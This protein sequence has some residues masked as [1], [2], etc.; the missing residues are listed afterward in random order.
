MKNNILILTILILGISCKNES[1]KI[2][3][4]QFNLTVKAENFPD[5]TKVYLYNRDIDKNIDSTYVINKT[6]EFSGKIDLPSLTYL[7]FFDKTGKSIEPYTYFYLENNLIE[8]EG[9]YDDFLN[10]K[11]TGSNQTD[12]QKKYDSIA[13]FIAKKA[14]QKI[15]EISDSIEIIKTKSRYNKMI[16]K[17]QNEF[18]FNHANNQMSIH[19]LLY[20]KKKITKDSLLVFYETLDSVNAHSV[21]GNELYQ[22]A[23]SRDIKVGDHYRD[24][25]GIDLDGKNHNLSDYAG[26]VILLDF[27]G[28]G[29]VPC[30]KQNKSEFQQLYNKYENDSFVLISYSLDTQKKFWKESSQQDDIRWVNISDLQGIMGENAKKYAVQAIPNSFLIDQNGI[31]VKSFIGF[32][33]GES[34]IED[35]IDKILK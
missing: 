20:R 19:T 3:S 16:W 7:N 22:Y 4:E 30:R 9:E 33:E 35:E 10:A 21:K 12:L 6:F 25:T 13:T 5:S 23:S 1:E 24:I 31:I 11:I 8:I 27:W 32:S 26:K 17:K 28:A 2:K 18:L 15:A 14:K 34:T 29:C